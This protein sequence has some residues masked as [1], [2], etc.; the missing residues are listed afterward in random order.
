MINTYHYDEGAP[1]RIYVANIG[2][3]NEGELVGGMALAAC[4]RR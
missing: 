1:I 4:E 2:K 3:Y